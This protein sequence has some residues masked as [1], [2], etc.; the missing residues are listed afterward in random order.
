MTIS[1]LT[2]AE[3]D[4]VVS[5]GDRDDLRDGNDNN[6]NN[7]NQQ[8]PPPPPSFSGR[9]LLLLGGDDDD[10]G[11]N[12]NPPT[13]HHTGR[14]LPPT[15]PWTTTTTTSEAMTM[16]RIPEDDDE[17][18]DFYLAD[19]DD[20]DDDDED[21]QQQLLLEMSMVTDLLQHGDVS[22]PYSHN[23]NQPEGEEEDDNDDD[24]SS[25]VQDR[26]R[27]L[28]LQHI[29][30]ALKQQHADAAAAAAATTTTTTP[31]PLMRTYARLD[32]NQQPVPVTSALKFAA[33]STSKPNP[34]YVRTLVVIVAA[35]QLIRSNSTR[36]IRDLYYLLKTLAPVDCIKALASSATVESDA[37]LSDRIRECF[38]K[39]SS[40]SSSNNNNNNSSNLE[41]AAAS[42]PPP[43]SP[44]F[45]KVDSVTS[46]VKSACA[47]LKCRRMD[48]HLCCSSKGS[49]AG[50]LV[51]HTARGAQLD[52]MT[53]GKGGIPIPGDISEIAEMKVTCNS[54]FV[55][56]VEKDAVF[57]QLVE[58]RVWERIEG[59]CVV[60]TARGM[61]DLAT[62]AFCFHLR[63]EMG[64]CMAESLLMDSDEKAVDYFAANAVVF[65]GLVD[66]NPAG[67]A[68]A[69]TYKYGGVHGGRGN[70][71][72]PQ[73]TTPQNERDEQHGQEEMKELTN[74]EEIMMA[75][76]KLRGCD[77]D[78][79]DEDAA[80]HQ[81]MSLVH[82]LT[83]RLQQ[84]AINTEPT[85]PAISCYD[86]DDDC[87]GEEDGGPCI[88]PPPPSRS[89]LPLPPSPP[90]SPAKM[91]PHDD[92]DA[93]IVK[94]SNVKKRCRPRG[95]GGGDGGATT[96]TQESA[97]YALGSNFKL[98]GLRECHLDQLQAD[99]DYAAAMDAAAFGTTSA[100]PSTTAIAFQPL[101][102]KDEAMLCTIVDGAWLV[103]LPENYTILSEAKA[104]R[105]RNGKAELE[106]VPDL[107][108]FVASEVEYG[109]YDDY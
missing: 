52:G 9:H 74:E 105:R 37:R 93:E 65:L 7:N 81:R 50:C 4:V 32:A 72:P 85:V 71:P 92:D 24:G 51:V 57:Q 17:Y 39:P 10:G 47:L 2:S 106:V 84:I 59:G 19:D 43:P 103:A 42:P 38:L 40:S 107:A 31:P 11:E 63:A 90:P 15:Q 23:N 35:Y 89:T 25:S 6:N 5:R 12:D 104:M 97:R 60:V 86:D 36:T 87:G 58:Q 102:A 41:A 100:V 49:Y 99:A 27:A 30:H 75:T 88:P 18:L 73:T 34:L 78:D 14:L 22:F 54:Q 70:E 1:A 76:K 95:G 77:D 94:N 45:P 96:T 53:T 44:L 101:T 82:Q 91:L 67:L 16:N 80:L 55:I 33:S 83:A 48:L 62:R 109:E 3:M 46:A 20:D 21:S 98:L 66:W 79:D 13:E 64:A 61:P 108:T 68:I 69:M 8:Q 29:K 26:V 28:V 56:I